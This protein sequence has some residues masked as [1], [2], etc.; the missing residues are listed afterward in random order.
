[1]S[2]RRRWRI[3]WARRSLGSAAHHAVVLREARL[4]D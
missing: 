3:A 4:A 1:M 2:V